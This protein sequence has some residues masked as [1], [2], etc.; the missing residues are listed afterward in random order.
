M[1]LSRLA[2]VGSLA[3]LPLAMASPALATGGDEHIDWG[4]WTELPPEHY[5]MVTTFT[6]CGGEEFTITA[7]D[8]RGADIRDATLEDGTFVGE[9]RGP[10]TIDI[11]RSDGAMIDELDVGGR[12][13]TYSYM[14]NTIVDTLWGASFLFP[15][16]PERSAKLIDVFGTD[17]V[18]W[19]DPGDYVTE[20]FGIDPDTGEILET[21]WDVQADIV[22]L[23][24]WFDEDEKH[25]DDDENDDDED[26]HDNDNDDKH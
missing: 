13:L 10:E 12:R 16:D 17:L 7:G 22:D 26:D 8:V 15:F 6:A 25:H 20:T 14:D 4:P 3:A 1:R 11:T 2:V 23:C 5:E 19:T 9:Y 21:D 24:Q 18:Y